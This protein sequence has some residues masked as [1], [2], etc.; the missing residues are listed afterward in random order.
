MVRKPRPAFTL[1]ELLVVIAIIAI[2]IGLL[3]PAVQKVREAAARMQSAN[4]LKQMGLALHMYN[5]TKGLLPPSFG[6]DPKLAS[7]E[8]A[9]AGGTYGT[10]HFHILPY[11][12]QEALF[13]Q[14]Y[15]TRYYT[16]VVG[17]DG[18]DYVTTF[19]PYSY[20]STNTGPGK[21]TR[22][23]SKYDYTKAP[24][25]YGYK[26]DYISTYNNYPTYTSI[27]ATQAY[28]ADAVSV[29]VKLYMAPHD[30]SLTQDNYPYTSYLINGEVLDKELSIQQMSDGSSNTM[31]MLEGYANC[32]GTPYRYGYWNQTYPGY[33]YTYTY[34]YTYTN[35]TVRTYGPYSYGFSYVPRIYQVPG[36]TFN[37]RPSPNKYPYECVGSQA[38]SLSS[39]SIMVLLGDGSVRG[40]SPGVTP[41]TW[42][43]ALT[44]AMGDTIGGDW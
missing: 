41:T 31:L 17:G 10:T 26:Y 15:Q 24:Y 6:W 32:Y 21:P 29:P 38:Q 27:P 39:G 14:S 30:P 3:L 1:I 34:T 43:A 37:V 35:G 25:N 28:W 42:N 7:G 20:T 16:Y 13:K 19:P 8:K 18:Y 9:K 40:V 5:D 12:E 22:Y 23:I 2:L 4:N 36:K 33:D 44:P 11:I